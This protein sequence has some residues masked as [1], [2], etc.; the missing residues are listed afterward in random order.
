MGGQRVNIIVFASRKGGAGKSTLAVHLAAH[1]AKPSVPTLLIDA[2]PQG[3]SSL[4]HE[5]RG[6]EYPALKRVTNG[7]ADAVKSAKKDG[8]QWVFIDTPPNASSTVA[9]AIGL[10]TLVVIPTR[11]CVFG[12]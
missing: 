5:L 2:D 12:V 3:S 9:D 10:A 6:S 11:P 8:Y 7:I 1:A 4:W